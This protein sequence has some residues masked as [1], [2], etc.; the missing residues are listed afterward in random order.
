LIKIWGLFLNKIIN[1][2][3]KI[4]KLKKSEKFFIG[5]EKREA[6]ILKRYR[7]KKWR[8]TAMD[9]EILV[10]NLIKIYH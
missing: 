1:I 10:S 8:E 4:K 6:K 2:K 3:L 7:I 9:A 5:V